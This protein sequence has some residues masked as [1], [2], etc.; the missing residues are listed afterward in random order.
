[1]QAEKQAE[2]QLEK[3]PDAGTSEQPEKRRKSARLAGLQAEMKKP[4]A[5][6][7]QAIEIIDEQSAETDTEEESNEDVEQSAGTETEEEN[8][9]ETEQSVE[10]ETEEEDVEGKEQSAET[11]T[12]EEDVEGK[13]QFCRGRNRRRRRIG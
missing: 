8:N 9:R 10:A 12:E 6:T 7:S 2:K 11:E 3:R 1:M 4:W 5:R 13:E